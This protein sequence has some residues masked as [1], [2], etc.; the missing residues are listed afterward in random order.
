MQTKLLTQYVL[1]LAKY[2]I[3][4]DI[5]DRARYLRQLLLPAEKVGPRLLGLFFAGCASAGTFHFFALSSCVVCVCVCVSACLSVCLSVCVF[6][7][8]A[9][10]LF[11]AVFTILP[12]T[13]DVALRAMILVLPC[14]SFQLHTDITHSMLR[15]LLL[16]CLI[17]CVLSTQLPS[18]TLQY[19]RGKTISS[20]IQVFVRNFQTSEYSKFCTRSFYN[21]MNI[22]KCA[23]ISQP[24]G[25]IMYS[26]T[27]SCHNYQWNS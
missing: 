5:R 15:Y 18:N 26:R 3:N 2:D 16:Q 14:S 1:N 21:A 7:S 24:W 9:D 6:E 4:Y 23:L 12:S 20:N 17:H 8:S 25:R 19:T 22:T 27:F 10:M 13:T 11:P